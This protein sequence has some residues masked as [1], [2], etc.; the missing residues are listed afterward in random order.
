MRTVQEDIDHMRQMWRE[1]EEEI[2]ED[3][4]EQ[5]NHEIKLAQLEAIQRL[6]EKEET[7]I[8]QGG[9]V[10]AGYIFANHTCSRCHFR[11]IVMV[12]F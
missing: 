1:R 8:R 7:D 2:K 5:R 11:E 10:P 9:E 12:D 3:R 4:R 6:A